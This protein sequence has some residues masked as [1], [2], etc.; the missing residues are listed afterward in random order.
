MQSKYTKKK[1][2]LSND[3]LKYHNL[4]GQLVRQNLLDLSYEACIFTSVRFSSINI[5]K[6]K[7]ASIVSYTSISVPVHK[8]GS[9]FHSMCNPQLY[10]LS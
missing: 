7:S 3:K 1:G 6:R 4:R 2:S 9:T 8:K 5:L 10:T